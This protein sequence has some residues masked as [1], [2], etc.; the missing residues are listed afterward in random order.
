MYSLY[1][2]IDTVR[3]SLHKNKNNSIKSR[4]KKYSTI[5]IYCQNSKNKKIE[6]LI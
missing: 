1:N 3:T 5:Y 6:L 2:T 4:Y